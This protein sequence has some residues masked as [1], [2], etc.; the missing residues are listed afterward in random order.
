MRAKH[1]MVARPKPRERGA[2]AR[3]AWRRLSAQ[4]DETV[5]SAGVFLKVVL[6]PHIFVFVLLLV[7]GSII[8]Q[9]IESLLLRIGALVALLGIGLFVSSFREFVSYR[10]LIGQV[11]AVSLAITIVSAIFRLEPLTHVYVPIA[12][13]LAPL[14]FRTLPVSVGG[15]VVAGVALLVVFYTPFAL[16]DWGIDRGVFV[17]VSGVLF[18]GGLVVGRSREIGPRSRREA[19]SRRNSRGQ[20]EIAPKEQLVGDTEDG[21]LRRDLKVLWNRTILGEF[22]GEV[23]WR[24]VALSVAVGGVVCGLVCTLEPLRPQLALAWVALAAIQVALVVQ[25]IQGR[26]FE[27]VARATLLSVF[28]V[29]GWWLIVVAEPRIEGILP[30]AILA[31]IIVW[32]APLPWSRRQS[33]LLCGIFTFAALVRLLDCP[34]AFLVWVELGFL[35]PVLV[36]L[37]V[38]A[39]LQLHAR[40]AQHFLRRIGEGS[41]ASL[42]ACRALAWQ[43]CTVLES[44]RALLLVGERRVEV[45]EGV[46]PHPTPVDPVFGRGLYQVIVGRGEEEGRLGFRD[47]SPQFL[48]PCIDWFGFVPTEFYF[49]RVSAIVEGREE[50]LIIVVPCTLSARISGH[51]RVLRVIGGL[52]AIVRGWLAAARGRFLSSDVLLV[53]QQS[54]SAREEDFNQVV[55]LVN[56]TAQDI[57]AECDEIRHLLRRG[58]SDAEQMAGT[59]DQIEHLV[60]SLSAGVSDVKLLKELLRVRV[61]PASDSVDLASLIEDLGIFGKH[62]ASRSGRSFRVAGECPPGRRLAVA[63][64]EFLAMVLRMLLRLAEGRA[65]AGSEI[66]LEVRST[67]VATTLAVVDS[68]PPLDRERIEREMTRLDDVAPN[69]R[70]LDCYRAAFNLARLSGGRFSIGLNDHGWEAGLEFSPAVEG[71]GATQ[72]GGWILLVDDNPHV[73]SFYARVAE[74]MQQRYFTAASVEEARDIVNR[75]GRPRLVVTDL[76]LGES[77]GL[78]LLRDLRVRFEADLPIIVVSGNTG[79][80]VAEEVRVAGATSYLAKPVGRSRLFS[81]LQTL[82]GGSVPRRSEG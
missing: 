79:P 37:S 62:R 80:E 24:V 14:L 75:E 29:V 4:L 71:G 33:F 70:A 7:V 16:V 9:G 44:R 47:L 23:L 81:E 19:V 50:Q 13:L 22:I 27:R 48:A 76:Q 53:S 65:P 51:T 21:G 58:V 3:A 38:M 77:S 34:S 68:G 5:G 6:I 54:I 36:R 30:E 73:T 25:I 18:V 59:V 61:L 52:A 64:G 32:V 66:R 15:L 17:G 20:E 78:D 60:L 74:A 40:A 8:E 72:A 49:V 57:S 12:G 41:P 31:L 26:E 28:V 11:L 2:G 69:D 67:G 63:S 55:H 46:L 10:L 35:C 82:L 56:N 45:L 39:A 1:R 42:A 43:V